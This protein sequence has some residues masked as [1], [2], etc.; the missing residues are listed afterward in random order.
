MLLFLLFDGV[1]KIMRVPQVLDAQTRLGYPAGLAPAIGII[2]LLCTA[3][4]AI[5]RTSIFGALLLTAYLGGAVAS[6]V[7][8]QAPAFDTSFPILFCILIWVPLFL[9]EPRLRAL[10]PFRS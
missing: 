3:V 9:R 5:P 4:Y 7:R 10:I 2:V 6:Q 1:T 8:I